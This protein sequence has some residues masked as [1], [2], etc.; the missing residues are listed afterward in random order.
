MVSITSDVVR[1]PPAG[2]TI[3]AGATTGSWLI[4]IHMC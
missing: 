4:L 2:I 1:F 3:P